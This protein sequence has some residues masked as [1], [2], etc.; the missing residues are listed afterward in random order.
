MSIKM[1]KKHIMS[2]MLDSLLT[3]IARLL[4]A[5]GVMFAD[6]GDLMK[7]AYLRAAMRQVPGKMTDSALSLAT[8][9]QRRDVARLRALPDMPRAR[10]DPLSRI[11]AQ[12]LSDPEYSVEAGPKV[13]PRKGDAP[14]FDALAAS[15]RKDLHPR[16]MFEKLL[17]AGTIACD[18]KLDEVTLVTRAYVPLAGSEAQM[19]YLVENLS[20]HAL[21]AVDNVTAP[22]PSHFERAVHYDGLTEADV[23][24]LKVAFYEGQ[25]QLLERINRMAAE[26]QAQAPTTAGYRF[27]AGGYFY[28]TGEVDE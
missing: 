6:F 27:R 17:D 13:I 14:S 23:L 5:Q 3:P 11:V 8:G 28:E 15:I 4:V 19:T 26:R 24:A 25:M 21:A 18:E 22:Q 10:P 20:D 1:C 16:T 12:W 9:L 7:R 2:N